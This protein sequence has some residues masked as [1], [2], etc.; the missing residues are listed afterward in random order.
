MSSSEQDA[1]K[2]Q[3]A[4]TT[5]QPT[6]DAEKPLL[7]GNSPPPGEEAKPTE[8]ATTADSAS[9]L[10]PKSEDKPKSASETPAAPETEEVPAIESKEP[11]QTVLASDEK[12]STNPSDDTERSDPTSTVD[13]APL[14]AEKPESKPSEEPVKEPTEDIAQDTEMTD[15]P[16]EKI[17]TAIEG[18]KSST[19]DEPPVTSQDPAALPTS[20]VDLGPSSLSQLAIDTTEKASSPAG[21]AVDLPMADAPSVKVARE[22]EDDPNEEPAPKRARTEPKEDEAVPEPSATD[23]P[24]DIQAEVIV[25]GTQSPGLSALTLTKFANW[26]D[27]ETNKREITPFQRREMRKVIGRVKKTKAGGHFRDSVQK[28]WPALWDSYVAKVEQP[29]D[30]AELER[31]LRDLNGPYN[32]YG[33]FRSDLRLVFENALFF[34]GPQHDVTASA[35]TA[36][37]A[38]WEEVLPI[39]SE[40]PV[41]PKAVPKPKPVRESRAVAN[42]DAVRRQSAGP[43]ASPARDAP[44]PKAAATQDQSADRRSSTATEGDRP[45]RTVRAPKPKDI[46]YTTKP[47]RKKLK[48]ELQFAEEV[49]TEVMSG[50]NHQLNAWF[51]EPV[52]AEGLNIPDYYSI[53][54][55]PMDLNKVSRM[56]AGGDFSNFKEFDKTIRLIFDNC[57]KFNGPVDQGNP[58]SLIAKQLEDVYVAQIKGKDAW[59]AKHAKTNAPASASNASDDEDEDEDDDGEEAGDAPVNNKEIEEL[60]AKL[61]EETKK[62]NSMFLTA[63]QSMIDIQK[64]IVAMVQKTLMEKAREVQSARAKAKSEK[65]KKASKAGKAK[66]AGSGG[67]K[68][69][70]G[71]SQPKKAG[72]SKKAATKKSLTAADKDLIANAINDLDGKNLD[73]AI[74]II[75]R[76]TGQ[77]V[78][79]HAPIPRCIRQWAGINDCS[80]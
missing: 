79:K 6:T 62:L 67:R 52:D 72:G 64:N 23:A 59:L 19:M 5:P 10:V 38:V 33:D 11:E 47:S 70:G 37:K 76:D 8:P 31:R 16:T 3:Q 48:P 73:T 14:P 54:K 65:P 12:K 66:A 61:D 25:S 74:D 28:L 1:N 46:D 44:A 35:A 15:A 53:I 75:K 34:N 42:A 7:N 29:M 69:T 56:L 78:S 63:N 24:S 20:E 43:T 36:V 50:K 22:R 45:K 55:K 30:L 17:E 77:N 2:E 13:R 49:L 27:E 68:S 71:A 4:D 80:C 41:K 39:P 18:D 57:Y 32:T 58:V 40:E 51:M 21:A 60:Q 26:V 9:E